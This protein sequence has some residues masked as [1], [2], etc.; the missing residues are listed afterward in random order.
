MSIKLI[1]DSIMKRCSGLN[2]FFVAILFID[3]IK[4][5]ETWL[6]KTAR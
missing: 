6:T 5:L 3:R 4:E 1:D 2:F